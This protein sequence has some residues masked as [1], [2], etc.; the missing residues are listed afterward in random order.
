[1]LISFIIYCEPG[2][3]LGTGDTALDKEEIYSSKTYML[4]GN[5]DKKKI[6]N[7]NIPSMLMKIKVK[8]RN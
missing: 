3:I 4:G 8:G 2:I 7:E 6:N 5:I 1:M